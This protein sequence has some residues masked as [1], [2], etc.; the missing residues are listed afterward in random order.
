MDDVRI[1]KFISLV[2]R[3]K[4]EVINAKLDSEGWLDIKTLLRGIENKFNI[5]FSLLDLKRIVKNDDK[6]RYSFDDTIDNI[7]AN[8]GHS[9]NVDLGLIPIKPPKTLYHGTGLKSVKSILDNGIIHMNRTYVHLSCDIDTATK[10]GLRHGELV[11]FKVDS[12]QMYK[13]RYKFYLSKNG[14]WLTDYIP[15][16]YIEILEED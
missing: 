13:D 1:S 10:V 11:I 7:R 6:Q 2:L 8:Q 4:P 9:I 15:K 14:V 16:K 12:E 3:H 5:K